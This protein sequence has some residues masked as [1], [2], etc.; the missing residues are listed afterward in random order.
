MVT[1]WTK[2]R[3][4]NRREEQLMGETQKS[5][6]VR[7]PPKNIHLYTLFACRTSQVQ[8]KNHGEQITYFA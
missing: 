5:L 4:N 1:G 7:S 6:T 3:V 2:D 8:L